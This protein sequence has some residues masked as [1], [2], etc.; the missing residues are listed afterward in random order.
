MNKL[1]LC[2]LIIYIFTPVAYS[3]TENVP[4]GDPIVSVEITNESGIPLAEHV[5]TV[6]GRRIALKGKVSG[7]NVIAGHQWTI[8]GDKIRTYSQSR[9]RGVKKV[10][11]SSDLQS[12]LVVFYWIDGGNDIEVTYTANVDGTTKSATVKINVERPTATLI[13]TTT[14]LQPP[15][16]LRLGH[17]RFGVL[18]PNEYGISWSGVVTTSDIGE[19]EVAF[20]QL[21]NADRRRTLKDEDSTK[22]KMTSNGLFFLDSLNNIVQYLSVVTPIGGNDTKS[23]S[24][25]DS[26]G[27][28]IENYSGGFGY[29]RISM[30]DQ[31]R[32]YLMYKPDGDGSIWVTLRRLDWFCNGAASLNDVNE[33]VLEPGQSSSHNPG[34]SNS[35]ELPEWPAC[36]Q[37]Q[38][39]VPDN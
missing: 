20:V 27:T 31:Y 26:P 19:G 3:Q 15:I 37:D 11:E 24:N 33:W 35:I 9:S 36:M 1:I 4:L 14:P 29:S 34:S 23:Q 22:M 16:G 8:G 10:I 6:P 18:A 12:E 38:A 32:L 7:G 28:D 17:L 5:R 13:S 30:N 21:V 2:I 25:T 39:W